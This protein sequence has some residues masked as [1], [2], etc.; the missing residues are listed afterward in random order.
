MAKL[1]KVLA[2]GAPMALSACATAPVPMQRIAEAQGA[3]RAAEEV[4][5]TENPTASY[6][7]KLARDQFDE[8]TL[9]VDRGENKRAAYILARA[10]ADAEL[11]LAL[12][13]EEKAQIQAR[14]LLEQVR[15]QG[16]QAIPRQNVPQDSS[17]SGQEGGL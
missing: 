1:I 10:E 12:S 15:A 17:R 14:E 8:A 13:R 2:L 4:G 16:T 7:L 11:A 6:H 5:A 3:I 9:L